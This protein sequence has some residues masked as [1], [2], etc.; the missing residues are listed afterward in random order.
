MIYV[1]KQCRKINDDRKIK[2]FLFS[3]LF[4]KSYTEKKAGRSVWVHVPETLH[5]L[6]ERL[7]LWLCKLDNPRV[8][9]CYLG[10]VSLNLIRR[11]RPLCWPTGSNFS[12][13]HGFQARSAWGGSLPSWLY[14]ILPQ[15]T[16]MMPFLLSCLQSLSPPEKPFLNHLATWFNQFRHQK[17][18]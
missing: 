9:E 14:Y 3:E 18:A 10:G 5:I 2:K 17:N 8:R 12:G 7:P 16:H 1:Y 4:C 6:N 15:P 11:G 13:S